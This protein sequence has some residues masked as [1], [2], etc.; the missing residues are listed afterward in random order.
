MIPYIK[1]HPIVFALIFVLA[2]AIPLMLSPVGALA[3]NPIAA[4]R[5]IVMDGRFSYDVAVVYDVFT[6]LGEQGRNIYFVFHI[7]D[8]VFAL[9]YALLMMAMLRPFALK[10]WVWIVFP[11]LPAAFDVIENTL[12]QIMSFQFPA[13]NH[14]LASTAS[15]FT[16][17]K[18]SAFALYLIVFAAMAVITRAKKK[19]KEEQT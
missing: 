19:S 10:K 1:K 4:E 14:T 12:I 8:N 3:V 15:V 5:V 6:Q 11:I 2:V 7:F 13:I 16:S 17:M 18:W 9:S